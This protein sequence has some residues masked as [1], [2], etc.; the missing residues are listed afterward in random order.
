MFD[1]KPS[2]EVETP[3]KSEREAGGL[4]LLEQVAADAVASNEQPSQKKTPLQRIRSMKIRKCRNPKAPVLFGISKTD[5]L[6]LVHKSKC[7]MWNCPTCKAR[8]A[9]RAIA[10][11]LNH[12]NSV[13]GQWYFITITPH[14]KAKKDGWSLANLRTNFHKLRKRMREEHGGHFDYF[15][16]WETF[17]DGEWHIHMI[18]NCE[19]PHEWGRKPSGKKGWASRWLKKAAAEC[20]LG[21]AADYEPL[22]NAGFAAHYVAKYLTKAL[23]EGVE[24]E[25]GQRRY[26]TS[27][28][29]TSL[30]DWSEEGDFEWEYIKDSAKMYKEGMKARALGIDIYISTSSQRPR[31][32][33]EL[34][35]WFVRGAGNKYFTNWDA[36]EKVKFLEGAERAKHE[37]L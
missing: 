17:K 37:P 2:F 20:G 9:Q 19:L 5:G 16:V 1:K 14:G 25:K 4:S 21:W 22:E 3:E 31:S 33:P 15:R 11:L 18:T 29:W 7:N 12:I 35:T 23:D 34:I 10:Y 32:V 30:E 24:W 13:G 6:A 8:K 36:Y 27:Q 26:Q 28:G